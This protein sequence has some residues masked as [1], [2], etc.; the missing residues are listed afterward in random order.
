M[1]ISSL[2]VKNGIKMHNSTGSKTQNHARVIKELP[3]KS[4]VHFNSK[5]AVAMRFCDDFVLVHDVI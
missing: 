4:R 3:Q 2:I 5:S 1:L